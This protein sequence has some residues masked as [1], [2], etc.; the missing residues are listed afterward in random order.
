MVKVSFRVKPRGTHGIAGETMWAE[1]VG[2]DR[3]RLANSPFHVL[4]VS[5][6]DVVFARRD[7]R[8]V[9]AFK[10]VS[11]R[12]GHST[13]W[14]ALR[15][16]VTDPS[17]RDGWAKL[18]ALGCGYEGASGRFLAMDV[19]PGVSFAVVRDLLDAGARQGAWEYEIAHRGHPDL[20]DERA[21]PPVPPERRTR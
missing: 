19:P 17:F 3:F 13:C 2:S 6:G 18:K 16:D 20:E 11:L 15:G 8:G 5:F 7:R 9:L 10:G 12:G 14:L 1:W 21:D 4:G